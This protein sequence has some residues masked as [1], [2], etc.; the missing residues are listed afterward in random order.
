VLSAAHRELLEETGLQAEQ[1]WL[2]GTV[3]VDVGEPIGIG[4][5]VMKGVCQ[6]GEPH[7][8]RE[9]ELEWVPFSEIQ[10]R[11]LVED[12]PFL[13]PRIILQTIQDPPFSA[14]YYYDEGDRLVVEF[15][16]K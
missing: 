1:L 12:L 4:I 6:E 8:S 9:G 15:R 13:L 2:A 14:R 10:T 11:E 3:T 16:E 7:G 5:F